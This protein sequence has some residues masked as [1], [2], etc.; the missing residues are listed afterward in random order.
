MYILK[1]V[2]SLLILMPLTGM[3]QIK[4]VIK[5]T[6]ECINY[7]ESLEGNIDSLTFVKTTTSES[8]LIY[9]LKN[10]QF[11]LIPS[12]F[13]PEYPGF[14]FEN[15]SVLNQ[16]LKKD[17]FPIGENFMTIWEL[18]RN[19]LNALPSG[20][21][22][23]NDFLFSDLGIKKSEVDMGTLKNLY[24]NVSKNLSKLDK[25]GKMKII[26]AYGIVFMDFL[27]KTLKYNWSFEK[28]YETYNS[29]KYPMVKLKGQTTDV[30]EILLISLQ[31]EKSNF[32]FFI[33][34][35]EM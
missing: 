16:M 34:L 13:N 1:Y 20:A 24:Q 3:S 4:Y 29:Y 23:Y 27:V 28:R 8:G 7:I 14:V 33:K 5:P 22:H 15:L 19:E 32:D 12:D 2:Y 6:V 26:I 31:E 25:K 21:N 35:M 18:E 10:D 11:V 17:F 9:K 30:I